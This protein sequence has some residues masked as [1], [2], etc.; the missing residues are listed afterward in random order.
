MPLIFNRS[1]ISTAGGDSYPSAAAYLTFSMPSTSN[2]L[3]NIQSVN[4]YQPASAGITAINSDPITGYSGGSPYGHLVSL[5]AGTYE[6]KFVFAEVYSG[7]NP[8]SATIE[9]YYGKRGSGPGDIVSVASFSAQDTTS[10][11][12]N[13]TY[14]Y[15]FE[16]VSTTTNILTFT[17]PS[18]NVVDY[19]LLCRILTGGTHTKRFGMSVQRTS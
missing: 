16:N 18:A 14:R 15:K 11:T 1:L 3:I 17:H 8:G 4:G 13:G 5:V 12:E 9:L 6:I 10:V 2:S 19:G 7:T